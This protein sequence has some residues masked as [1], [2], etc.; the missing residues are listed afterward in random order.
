MEIKAVIFDMDGLMLDTEKLLVKYW[1]EA[2]NKLGFPM[3][4]K[5]ALALRSFS[6]KFAI[7]KLKEWFGEDCEYMAIHDLRVKLMKEYTDVH[8]I[9]K[10][11]GLDTL[12]DYLTTHGY[13]TAVATATNIERAEEYL[14][15]IGVYDKFETIICGNMLE[16]GKPCPDIYLYACERLGLEPSQCMALEDSP[17]GGKSASSAGCVTVM[18]PDLTQPE[19]EQLNA[20]YAVAP[21]LDKV[22]DVLERA[23]G[24]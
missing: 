13:R 24:E 12:L 10:K 9:E 16:N 22:I 11:Q 6:R 7:P 20:V 19:E 23:K 18:V 3:E 21:S 2:A 5:H 1:C 4:R 14:K 17:N 8:G 15:K